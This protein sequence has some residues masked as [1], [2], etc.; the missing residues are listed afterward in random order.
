M[1]ARVEYTIRGW[2]PAAAQAGSPATAIPSFEAK[3]QMVDPLLFT[4]RDV[5]KLNAPQPGD[6]MLG[7]PPRPASLSYLDIDEDRKLWNDFLDRHLTEPAANPSEARMLAV[8]AQMR[9]HERELSARL[10]SEP[11]S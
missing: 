9:E 11:R 8:L 6:L 1:S 4:W 2:E 5:L 7:P 3:R 10:L